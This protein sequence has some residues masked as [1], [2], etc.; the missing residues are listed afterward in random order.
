MVE[1]QP[2]S[3]M[4]D[5]RKMRG[6]AGIVARIAGIPGIAHGTRN[7]SGRGSGCAPSYRDIDRY[8]A[9]RSG[10]GESVIDFPRCMCANRRLPRRVA[11]WCHGGALQIGQVEQYPESSERWR[12]TGSYVIANSQRPKAASQLEAYA[13]TRVFLA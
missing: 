2:I 13:W 7:P 1:Q 11:Q 8:H 9:D 6:I 4:L 3:T 5:H 10:S 12:L